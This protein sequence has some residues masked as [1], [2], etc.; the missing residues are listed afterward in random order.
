MSDVLAVP[1]VT[2]TLPVARGIYDAKRLRSQRDVIRDVMLEANDRRWPEEYGWLTL[3]RIAKLTGFGETSISAQLRHLRKACNGGYLV[4][5][6]MRAD[7]TWE[8]RLSK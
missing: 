7:G 8:Y 2:D 6:R 3:A 4:E 1:A 5:K